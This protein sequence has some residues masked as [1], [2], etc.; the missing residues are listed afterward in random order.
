MRSHLLP[1]GWMSSEILKANGK[2]QSTPQQRPEIY[3]ANQH[4]TSVWRY[5]S[6]HCY[7]S[8]HGLTY[9][10]TAISGRVDQRVGMIARPDPIGCRIYQ[11]QN[12]VNV[13]G[14]VR[15]CNHCIWPRVIVERWWHPVLDVTS[16][17]LPALVS[18]QLLALHRCQ[19]SGYHLKQNAFG[20]HENETIRVTGC[21]CQL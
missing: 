2:L 20:C 10:T 3:S 7:K 14:T 6:Q 21:G 9:I 16:C 12:I 8:V 15:S 5:N 11:W 4:E 1:Q 17:T 18:N 19:N 13:R